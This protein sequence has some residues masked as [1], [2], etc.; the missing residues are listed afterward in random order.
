MFDIVLHQAFEWLCEALSYSLM[1]M[2]YGQFQECLLVVGAT[3]L[4]SLDM[5]S[6]ELMSSGMTYL[7]M[8]PPELRSLEMM[9][10]LDEIF[11]KLA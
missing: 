4:K 6:L 5:I 1:I 11:I 3:K 2:D 7:E 8:I 9:S 10:I